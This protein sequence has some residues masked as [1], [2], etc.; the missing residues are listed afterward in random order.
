MSRAKF[1]LAAA[2]VALV[3]A[4]S[5][6]LAQER[7]W[8]GS[9]ARS[10][11]VIATNDVKA[12]PQSG[13]F[14]KAAEVEAERRARS[15]AATPDV[16]ISAGVG[17]D[18]MPPPGEA[19]LPMFTAETSEGPPQAETGPIATAR[20]EPQ[21]LG[22]PT[23]TAPSEAAPADDPFSI[24]MGAPAAPARAQSYAANRDFPEYSVRREAR[25]DII[26]NVQVAPPPLLVNPA[27]AAAA[28]AAAAATPQGRRALLPPPAPPRTP[29]PA[30]MASAEAQSQAP[31]DARA[32]FGFGA[33]ATSSAKA[34][35][36]SSSSRMASF[37]SSAAPTPPIPA[38]PE[39]VLVEALES[40]SLMAE[41]PSAASTPA[42]PPPPR[43]NRT[44]TV[45][46]TFSAVDG[47]R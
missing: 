38:S 28:A 45:L 40:D 44:T 14:G 37:G 13:W 17:A 29:D 12:Q 32:P 16:E 19:M 3:L 47:A 10:S 43:V 39:P 25:E 27:E 31:S 22:G 46:R 35:K 6:V 2:P 11:G 24:M 23:E 26:A 41:P 8:F 33:G 5:P 1:C 34:A 36:A 30:S 18:S 20:S 42:L 15:Q 21:L 9:G 7:G 4:A